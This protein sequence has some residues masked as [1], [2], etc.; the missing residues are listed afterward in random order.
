VITYAGYIIGFPTETPESIR[1]DIEV[2]QRELPVDILGFTMLTPLPGS[3]DHR[4]MYRAGTWMDPDLNK[5]DLE[6]VTIRHP[7]MSAEE[8]QQVYRDVWDWYYTPAHIETLMRR[9]VADGMKAVRIWQR[10]MQIYAVMKFHGVHPQQGGFF[11]RRVRL[12][13]RPGLPIEPAWRFWPK[14]LAELAATYGGLFAFGWR[15]HWLR[16][17][18]QRDPAARA[19]RD[20]AITPVV[21]AENEALELFTLSDSARGAVDR[22]RRLKTLAAAPRAT[23]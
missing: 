3:E 21:D 20:V 4:N 15:Y 18:I 11:R 14:R 13:R 10:V 9:A 8:L 6:H 2:I 7:L 1:H 5:Y 17:R 16:K 23:A 19:Y 22:A 12:D